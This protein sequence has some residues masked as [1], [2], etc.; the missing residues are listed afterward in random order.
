MKS[1]DLIIIGGGAGGFAAA[2]KSNSIGAKTLLINDGLEIGGTCV[3]VGCVPSKTLIYISNIIKKAKTFNFQINYN[4]EEIMNYQQE[5]VENLRNKKYVN[6][7]KLLENVDYVKGFAKFLNENEIEVNGET[8]YGKKFI[9]STGSKVAIPNIDG[10]KDVHYLDHISVLK[11]KEIPK[12][13]AIIGGGYIGLEYGQ[14]FN[15]MGSKVYI[16]EAMDKI[17]P[18]AEQSIVKKLIEFLKND[19]IEILTSVKVLKV[20]KKNKK[21]LTF[22][23]NNNEQLIE[24]DEIMI[25]TGKIPN[26]ENLNLEKIGIKLNEKMAIVVDDY[27]RTNKEHIFAVGD[28]IDK[29]LRLETTAGYEGTIAVENALLNS[30]KTIDYKL[31]PWTIFTNPEFSSIGLTEKEVIEKYGKCYC[32]MIDFEN[33]AKSYITKS[34]GAIK[35]V[36][37]ENYEI[38]GIHILS[39]NASEVINQGIYILKNKMKVQEIIETLPIFPSFSESIKLCALSF[40]MDI[41]KLPCCV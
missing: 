5:I 27:F 26:T 32:R 41:K 12:T 16:L 20:E 8:F 22:I 36:V 31:V 19:G 13:I 35:M 15:K 6:V 28:V 7:I 40:F 23:L 10:I 30:F 14:F 3:N 1:Y 11:I 17:L 18:F 2:I 33:L 24:V 34:M 25:A 39:E 29:P 38:L 9:I 37:N 21:V 4:F